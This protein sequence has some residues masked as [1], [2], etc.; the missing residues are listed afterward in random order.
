MATYNMAHYIDA[1]IYSTLYQTFEDFEFIIVD[2]ASQD[3]TVEKIK[4][5]L[6]P[7]LK[8]LVNKENLK[9]GYSRNRA[10]EHASGEYIAV[11]DADDI[12]MPNRLAVQV[13]YL[14]AHPEIDVVGSNCYVFNAQG[15]IIGRIMK[16]GQHE[17]LIKNIHLDLP[18][19][20]PTIM[21]RAD[22]F[23]KY[24]YRPEYP[25][26]QDYELFLKSYKTSRFGNIPEFLYAYYDTGQINL[27]KY[28]KSI[29]HNIR[30]FSRHWR[31]Y[32]LPIKSII[33]LPL[34]FMGR[35]YYSLILYFCGKSIFW[36]SN[37]NFPADKKIM[38]DQEWIMHCFTH[39]NNKLNKYNIK[40]N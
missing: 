8:L 13:E 40:F 11:C 17:D 30:M 32:E 22:W 23:K 15:K 16:S 38:Q 34:I 1:I 7:R 5:Y 37:K 36:R 25:R 3:D 19:I 21:A 39:K 29:C 12:N 27:K 33:K 31:E 20:H 6:D 9:S 35:G 18:L 10:I 26:G 24:K 14:D 28:L 2:D 4:A